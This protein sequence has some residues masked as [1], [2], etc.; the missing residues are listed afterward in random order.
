MTKCKKGWQLL[1]H[2]TQT[3][4]KWHEP[5]HS[6]TTSGVQGAH[7]EDAPGRWCRPSP[8][9]WTNFRLHW[10]RHQGSLPRGL[11]R[12]LFIRVFLCVQFQISGID[13]LKNDR[14]LTMIC[15]QPWDKNKTVLKSS[16]YIWYSAA[17][18]YSPCQVCQSQRGKQNHFNISDI[19][20]TGNWRAGYNQLVCHWFGVS[21]VLRLLTSDYVRIAS[22]S[23]MVTQVTGSA[24]LC[25]DS[26]SVG[27]L[28]FWCS[29]CCKQLCDNFKLACNCIG[30]G[31]RQS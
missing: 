10:C 18:K 19:C 1:W 14:K 22:R 16:K 6:G 20:Y 12:N 4:L 24:K 21:E 7:Q 25:H 27:N 13:G 15:K 11:S 30:E 8:P 31:G 28:I 3:L 2:D 17:P 5:L 9:C 29:E 23:K 26:L